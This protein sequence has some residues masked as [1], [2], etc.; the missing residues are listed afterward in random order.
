[1]YNGIDARDGKAV[2]AVSYRPFW[3]SFFHPRATGLLIVVIVFLVLNAV[4]NTF[5]AVGAISRG[6]GTEAAGN[7]AAIALYAAPAY[8]LAKLKRWAR[9]FEICFSIVMVVLG[10]ITMFAASMV[11]GVFIVATHG[12]VGIYLLSERCRKVFFPPEES[13]EEKSRS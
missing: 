3:W 7:L 11:M 9:M 10:F 6:A 1:M 2:I 4:L 5:A 13:E 8:G 12:L